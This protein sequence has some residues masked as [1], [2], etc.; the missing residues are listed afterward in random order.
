MCP[1]CFCG[2]F[3]ENRLCL[4]GKTVPR[5]QVVQEITDFLK[6]VLVLGHVTCLKT[7]WYLKNEILCSW[8]WQKYWT[9]LLEI[10]EHMFLVRECR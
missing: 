1:Q 3:V 8:F 10:F 4:V 6:N 5:I 7:S 2:Q 9:D